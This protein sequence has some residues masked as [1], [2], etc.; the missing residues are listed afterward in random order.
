MDKR[1]SSGTSVPSYFTA[2]CKTNFATVGQAIPFTTMLTESNSGFDPAKGTMTTK[3]S[4]LYFFTVSVMKASGSTTRIFLMHNYTK[5]GQ[6]LSNTARYGMLTLSATIPMKANDKVWIQLGQGSIGDSQT[7][8][9]FTGV[10]L[11]N[12]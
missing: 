8:G 3:I 6:A 2:S 10:K 9:L 12:I 1:I 5:I 7:Y 11:S 4:G